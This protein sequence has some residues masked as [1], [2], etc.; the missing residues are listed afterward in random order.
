[1]HFIHNSALLSL[2]PFLFFVFPCTLLAGYV[3]ELQAEYFGGDDEEVLAGSSSMSTS[4][5]LNSMVFVCV[6][7]RENKS[8][9][10]T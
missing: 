3:L 10:E 4:E 8:Y 9:G 6:S 1:M 5:C 2:V 7:V